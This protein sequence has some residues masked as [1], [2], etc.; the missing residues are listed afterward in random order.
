[1][2][3]ADPICCY[4]AVREHAFLNHMSVSLADSFTWLAAEVEI[5]QTISRPTQVRINNLV[6]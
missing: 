6:T 5:I 2:I 1:M 4:I 3:Q